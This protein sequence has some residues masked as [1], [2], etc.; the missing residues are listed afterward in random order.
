MLI[1]H[2]RITDED[3]GHWER[4]EQLDAVYAR[5]QGRRL[6]RLAESAR[7]CIATFGEKRRGYI[8]VS[9]GKDSVVVADLAMQVLPDWPLVW[10]RVE[11]IANPDCALVRDAFLRGRPSALT[12]EEIEVWCER[13]S[14]GEWHASG[15]LE[16]GFATAGSVHG[17]SYVSGIRAEESGIRKLRLLTHG[18]STRHTCAPISRWTAADVFAYLHRRNLPVHPAYACTDGGLFDRGRLRV[19]SLSGKRGTG[20]GR[21]EWEGRYYRDRLR[22]MERGYDV[23]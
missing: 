7:E 19:A 14:D 4:M 23:D 13:G 6:D 20:R 17:A 8:G 12:Y 21:A 15:T 1:D 11:P 3:R 18:T 9:W 2:P 5:A 10:V 16:R 22:A